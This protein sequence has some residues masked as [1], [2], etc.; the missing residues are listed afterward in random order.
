MPQLKTAI[1]GVP[2][3]EIYPREI[4]VGSQ[5]PDNLISY[6]TEMGALVQEQAAPPT[7][8]ARGSK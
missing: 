4:P 7:A 2:D 6:A 1:I 5:C 8:K 3:G